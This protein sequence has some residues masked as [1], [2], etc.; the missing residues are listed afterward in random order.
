M[1]KV[2]VGDREGGGKWVN[3][4]RGGIRFPTV[5]L[6]IVTIGELGVCFPN[7]NSERDRKKIQ[8]LLKSG[9]AI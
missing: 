8:Q 6:F 7:Q 2:V 3:E 9:C 1:N 5:H 4:S